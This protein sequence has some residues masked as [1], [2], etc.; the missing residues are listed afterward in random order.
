[1]EKS[2]Y[3][4]YEKKHSNRKLN[5]PYLSLF[6]SENNNN[7]PKHTNKQKKS[8]EKRKQINHHAI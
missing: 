4:F 8:S 5:V 3:I 2:I 7:T 6:Y 1:M